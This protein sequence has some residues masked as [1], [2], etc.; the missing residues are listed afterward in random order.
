MEALQA[1]QFYIC[2]PILESYT[3]SPPLLLPSN[4]PFRHPSSC[5]PLQQKEQHK[6][7][8]GMKNQA[9][10]LGAPRE[11]QKTKKKLPLGL[12]I[13]KS[14]TFRHQ[15]LPGS[16]AD[17]NHDC[18]TVIDIGPNGCV[19]IQYNTTQHETTLRHATQRNFR[20]VALYGIAPHCTALHCIVLYC[21][22]CNHCG[23]CR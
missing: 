12:A 6:S 19:S 5:K 13:T 15:G 17:I 8:F 11:R 14:A 20:C 1:I 4:L 9:T 16:D 21:I 7:H 2:Q 10:A 3:P 18:S 22:V 23:L